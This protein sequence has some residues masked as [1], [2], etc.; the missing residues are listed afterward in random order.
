MSIIYR[1]S[2]RTFYSHHIRDN[3]PDS[4]RFPLHVH[5]VHEFCYFIA[6]GGRFFIESSAYDLYPG[7]ILLMRAGEAHRLQVNTSMPYERITVE[8]SPSLFSDFDLQSQLTEAFVKRPAG[9]FNLYTPEMLDRELTHACMRLLSAQFQVIPD[10]QKRMTMIACLSPVL[11]EI[12]RAFLTRIS[13]QPFQDERTVTAVSQL[14]EYI[15]AHLCEKLDLNLLAQRF[16]ISKTHLNNQFKQVTGCTIWEYIIIKRL[17]LARKYIRDGMSA[18][19]AALSSGWSDYS[20][21]YRSYKARF[22]VSPLADKQSNLAKLRPEY[23]I[24]RELPE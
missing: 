17:V 14:I 22:G 18:G 10:Q 24:R 2:E 8:F 9:Q 20:S 5:D 11:L 21:F 15:N 13:A 1:Y 7:C 4:D 16:F 12:N 19:E 3:N 23:D 6:G